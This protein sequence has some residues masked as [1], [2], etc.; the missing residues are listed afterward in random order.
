MICTPLAQLQ[1][2]TRR[3]CQRAR[4]QRLPG[5]G[6]GLEC[7]A[8]PCDQQL[9]PWAA[10]PYAVIVRSLKPG[11]QGGSCCDEGEDPGVCRRS[12]RPHRG[13]PSTQGVPKDAQ[14]HVV[15]LLF[16]IVLL[17]KW[18]VL[19]AELEREAG[20]V[21]GGL[22]TAVR[23]STRSTRARTRTDVSREQHISQHMPPPPPPPMAQAEGAAPRPQVRAR[24]C[25]CARHA[26]ER[27]WVV[28]TS[29]CR[30]GISQCQLLRV[31]RSRGPLRRRWPSAALQGRGASSRT[32]PRP[33]GNESAT[34]RARAAS[35]TVRITHV[36]L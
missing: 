32:R 13:R 23:L 14:S 26:V 6:G 21:A 36:R 2:S 12:R 33:H 18:S 15:A 8:L 31:S 3:L 1:P 28:W 16:R 10:T 7:V 24:H 25:C 35:Q 30:V 34:P 4:V 22:G 27:R 9:L 20:G 11:N 29:A 17:T 19:Q 5:G